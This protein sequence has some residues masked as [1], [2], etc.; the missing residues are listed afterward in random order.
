MRRDQFLRNSCILCIGAFAGL[1]LESCAST[2]YVGGTISEGKLQVSLKEFTA[3]NKKGESRQRK[4]I[5]V[6]NDSLKYPIAVFRN[7]NDYQATWM[8]CSHQG[9][10]LQ[11][12][13]EVLHCPAHGSEFGKQGQVLEGP[14]DKPLRTFKTMTT[15]DHLF[16]LLEQ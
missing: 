3:T 8:R 5:V 9:T 10:E 12:A 16:I 1:S 15:S 6:R 4:H 2:H 7:E 14:A 11:L 13:G